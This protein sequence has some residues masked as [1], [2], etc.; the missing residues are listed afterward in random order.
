MVELVYKNKNYNKSTKYSINLLQRNTK[1]V[2]NEFL[3]SRNV[4]DIAPITISLGY[5]IN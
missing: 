3:K 4:P 5:Y 2:T 1:A